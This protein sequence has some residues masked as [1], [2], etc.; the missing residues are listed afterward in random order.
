MPRTARRIGIAMR[1]VV[2]SLAIGCLPAA[3][4]IAADFWDTRAFPEWSAQEIDRLLSDSPWARSVNVHVTNVGLAGRVGGL[5]GGVVG[6]GAGS[7]GGVGA[8]GGGVAGAGAGNI[9]G[10]TFMP[11]P[12]R[13]RVPVVWSS[14]LPVRQ[15]MARL[16]AGGDGA[17]LA[18]RPELGGDEPLY[19]IT[20]VVPAELSEEITSLEALRDTT[21]L[22]TRRTRERPPF[23]IRLFF[24][25][26]LLGLEFDFERAPAITL[27]DREV[28]FATEIGSTSI[29]RTFRLSDMTVDG[30]LRL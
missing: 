29:K 5:G 9:G 23:D 24:Q 22:A 30:E 19:R 21:T 7:R 26:A 8:G 12:R 4:P 27:Q 11:P 20:I 15:A 14:A 18:Q 10:G 17:D 28:E 1:V 16:T 25:D 13:V 6:A 2:W 3:V